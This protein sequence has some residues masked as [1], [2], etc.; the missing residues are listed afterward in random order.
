MP[1][2]FVCLFVFW[3]FFASLSPPDLTQRQL[4]RGCSRSTVA[5]EPTVEEDAS[6]AGGLSFGCSSWEGWRAQSRQREQ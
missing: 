4:A 3:V 5:M 2:L 6:G 1:I